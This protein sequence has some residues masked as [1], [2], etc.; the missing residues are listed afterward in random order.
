MDIDNSIKIGS[1]LVVKQNFPLIRTKYSDFCEINILKNNYITENC[2][3]K[4][5]KLV[6]VF[7]QKLTNANSWLY[8]FP[9]KISLSTTCR[10]QNKRKIAD[11]EGAGKISLSEGCRLSTGAF[12]IVGNKKILSKIINNFKTMIR[13]D[14]KIKEPL[15]QIMDRN[16]TS[17]LLNDEPIE[18]KF[19]NKDNLNQLS[20]DASDLNEYQ[21]T[22]SEIMKLWNHKSSDFSISKWDIFF[23]ALKGLLIF[24]VV[25]TCIIRPCLRIYSACF[26]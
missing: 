19:K 25:Y 3:I 14:L 18:I 15:K 9:K 22:N 23:Y 20:K 6:N 7:L 16:F 1:K 4:T 10:Y 17:I 21:Q 5:S 2:I 13:I 8:V 11:F 26:K 12:S 24:A